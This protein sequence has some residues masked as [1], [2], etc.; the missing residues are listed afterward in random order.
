MHSYRFAYIN[1]SPSHNA[2]L[3]V[4]LHQSITI[5]QCTATWLPTPINCHPTMQYYRFAYIYISLSVKCQAE[6]RTRC[7][8]IW[9][10]P[11]LQMYGR[12]GM[13][14]NLWT[15]PALMW[16][17]NAM[18]TSTGSVFSLSVLVGLPNR[19]SIC[20]IQFDMSGPIT[21]MLILLKEVWWIWRPWSWGCLI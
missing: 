1:Q 9:S 19:I 13:L 4:S 10:L 3:L 7:V 2:L 18:L 15:C 21:L 20:Y 5:S 14:T 17:V 12:Q 6:V 8:H 11:P 16:L